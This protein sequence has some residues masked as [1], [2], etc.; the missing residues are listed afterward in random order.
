MQEYLHDDETLSGHVGAI[1]ISVGR[2]MLEPW[3]TGHLQGLLWSADRDM[4]A[5]RALKGRTVPP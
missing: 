4:Y 2:S 5:R 3:D 1:G